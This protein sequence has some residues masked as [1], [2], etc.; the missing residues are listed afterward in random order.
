MNDPASAPWQRAVRQ[1]CRWWP[2]LPQSNR[3]AKLIGANGRLP[4]E[5][6]VV[7]TRWRTRVRVHPDPIFHRVWTFGDYEPFL[8]RVFQNL[9]RPGDVIIDAGGSFGWYASLF[10][11]W[12]GPQGCVHSIEPIPTIHA[13]LKDT[14]EL[15]ALSQVVRPH[16]MALGR[17]PGELVVN[18]FDDL[19]IGFSSATQGNRPDARR[20]V[21]PVT[22]LDDLV[23]RERLTRVD[24]IK[25]DVEGWEPEVFAGGPVLLSRDDAPLVHFE[26]NRACVR[27]RGIDPDAIFGL[28]RGFGYLNFHL[29]QSRMGVVEVAGWR[30]LESGDYLA[31]K[32]VH[33]DRIA[34]ARHTSRW[35]YG[36]AIG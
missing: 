24:F 15:N 10:G 23:A 13:L 2:F 22:R 6:T 29:A 11:Q 9:V 33:Q 20:H 5:P 3:F 34:H 31:S 18:T 27:D 28:L 14:I 30:D 1:L 36:R 32:P 21:C 26:V 16:L 4:I 35:F 12:V 19:G 8:T 7:P 17:E 25:A